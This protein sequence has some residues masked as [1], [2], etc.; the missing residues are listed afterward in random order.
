MAQKVTGYIKLQIEAGKA[1]PAPPVGPALGQKGDVYK[2]QR[3]VRQDDIADFQRFHWLFLAVIEKSSPA[4]EPDFWGTNPLSHGLRRASSPE[5]GSP[6]I[7]P[8]QA[9]CG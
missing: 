8:K 2:R 4:G 7:C 9:S 3:P 1:T 6:F 5:R